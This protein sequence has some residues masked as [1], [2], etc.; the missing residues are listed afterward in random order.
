MRIKSINE[1]KALLLLE[2]HKHC[3]QTMHALSRALYVGIRNS[4]ITLLGALLLLVALSDIKATTLMFLAFIGTI[5]PLFYIAVRAFFE[6]RDAIRRGDHNS[7]LKLALRLPE[8]TS[9]IVPYGLPF[10]LSVIFYEAYSTLTT[11]TFASS[12]LLGTCLIVT[13]YSATLFLFN[14]AKPAHEARNKKSAMDVA[15]SEFETSDSG[16]QTAVLKRFGFYLSSSHN[17]FGSLLTSKEEQSAVIEAG[18]GVIKS[19]SQARDAIY[20]QNGLM[21]CL[22]T[23]ATVI[24]MYIAHHGLVTLTDSQAASY[25]LSLMMG[26]FGLYVGRHIGL[27][28]SVNPTLDFT[29]TNEHDAYDHTGPRASDLIRSRAFSVTSPLIPVVMMALALAPSTL[30]SSATAE[31]AFQ[32][33]L[34][35]FLPLLLN[36]AVTRMS[37]SIIAS[38]ERDID[39]LRRDVAYAKKK[40]NVL[41]FHRKHKASA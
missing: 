36:A 34:I 25:P 1:G 29:T 8:Q 32:L 12:M 10:G 27:S 37:L 11:G 21:T 30:F 9:K 17:K 6:R 15:L 41:Q 35:T 7:I 4:L 33:A 5:A 40:T 28:L 39:A 24:F 19:H 16:K 14:S 38:T 18:K 22:I 2:R 20:L 3:D 31:V 13:V 26:L 23:V